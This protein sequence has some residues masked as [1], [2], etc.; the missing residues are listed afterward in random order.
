MRVCKSKREGH[1]CYVYIRIHGDNANTYIR[2]GINIYKYST[3]ISVDLPDG[4]VAVLPPPTGPPP[5][6]PSLGALIIPALILRYLKDDFGIR[7]LFHVSHDFRLFY[8]TRSFSS[9][10]CALC[11]HKISPQARTRKQSEKGCTLKFFLDKLA[12]LC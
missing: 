10:H 11:I 5:A 7:L 12:F 2:M 6:P 8:T 4:A 3:W 1:K 9:Y